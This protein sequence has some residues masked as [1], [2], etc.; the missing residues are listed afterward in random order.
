MCEQS[1]MST[2]AASTLTAPPLNLSRSYA[3]EILNG[4]RTPSRSLA[5]QIYR[6]TG[7]KH[8]R[9]AGLSD[10]EIDMLERI[11]PARAA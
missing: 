1:A 5:I 8:K 4:K 2:P 10:T 3:W 9:L 11:E 6:K 7:W